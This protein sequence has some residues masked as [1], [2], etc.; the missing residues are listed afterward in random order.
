MV[1]QNIKPNAVSIDT[2][3]ARSVDRTDFAANLE[4]L[5]RLSDKINLHP[6]GTTYEILFS[7]A[8]RLHCYATARALWQRACLDACVRFDMRRLVINSLKTAFLFNDTA[9]LAGSEPRHRDLWYLTA[10][11][12]VTN[13]TTRADAAG[14]PELTGSATNR[15]RQAYKFALDIVQSDMMLFKTLKPV[16]SLTALLAASISTDMNRVGTLE[17]SSKNAIDDLLHSAPVVRMI[18]R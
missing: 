5:D 14:Y 9:K 3:F 1:N 7:V 16:G 15:K 6:D 17:G 4:H 10:G 13:S 2:I 11:I 12:F 18:P 8:W